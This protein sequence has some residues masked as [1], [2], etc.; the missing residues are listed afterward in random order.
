MSMVKRVAALLKMEVRDVV[1]ADSITANSSPR[2]PPKGK[3]NA[4]FKIYR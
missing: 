4:N 3:V 2:N 1:M